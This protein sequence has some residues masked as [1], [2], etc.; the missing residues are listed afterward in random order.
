MGD[1]G[2]AK[3]DLGPWMSCAMRFGDDRSSRVCRRE[4]HRCYG[5]QPGGQQRVAFK[6]DRGRVGALDGGAAGR[7]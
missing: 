3:D 6:M 5:T 2:H 7:M 4:K 1:E